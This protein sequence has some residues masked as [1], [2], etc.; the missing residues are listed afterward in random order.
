VILSKS[1]RSDGDDKFTADSVGSEVNFG[2]GGGSAENFFVDFGE[3]SSDGD[4]LFG[5]ADFDEFVEEAWESV[6]G[7]VKNGCDFLVGKGF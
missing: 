2:F 7:F 1:R 4:F 6:G 3:F 5:G